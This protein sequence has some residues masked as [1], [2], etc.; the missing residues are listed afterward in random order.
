MNRKGSVLVGVKVQGMR[1]IHIGSVA[2]DSLLSNAWFTSDKI[3][4]Q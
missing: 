2:V 4:P 3:R 1:L